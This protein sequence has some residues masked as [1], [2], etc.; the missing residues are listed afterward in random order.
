MSFLDVLAD[1]FEERFRVVAG[2]SLA[3]LDLEED[4]LHVSRPDA[5]GWLEITLPAEGIL[6]GESV[7]PDDRGVLWPGARVRLDLCNPNSLDQF[8]WWAE[9]CLDMMV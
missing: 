5:S 4:T 2:I 3:E 6:L 9:E 1:E 7:L 8:W